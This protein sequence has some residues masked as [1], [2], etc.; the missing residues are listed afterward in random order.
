VYDTSLPG[1]EDRLYNLIP[2]LQNKEIRTLLTM[3][4]HA[5]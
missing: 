5:A 4:L 3:S 1:G 2:G